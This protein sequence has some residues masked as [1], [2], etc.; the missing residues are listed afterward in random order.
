MPREAPPTVCQ[1]PHNE[2]LGNTTAVD[3]LSTL[4]PSQKSPW[5]HV[6]AACAFEK[7]FNAGLEYAMDNLRA[8]S[9]QL[10]DARARILDARDRIRHQ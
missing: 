3:A 6:C 7:G 4:P 8:V 1:L 9:H 10:L 2:I 5:R